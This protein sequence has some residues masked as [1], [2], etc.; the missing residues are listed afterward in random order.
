M[1]EMLLN[2]LYGSEEARQD[3]E[4]KLAQA[5]LVE[6]VA[7]EAGVDL[8]ELDD[9]ELEKFA[10]YVLSD[11]D[12]VIEVSS[13][14]DVE[15]VVGEDNEK[16]AEAELMGRTMAR[17]YAD[18]LSQI[19]SEGG[20]MD[21]VASA[22]ED[23]A[24]AWEMQKIAESDNSGRNAAIGGAAGAA[25]LG[26][27]A[28][29][30]RALS[31]KMLSNR[32]GDLGA[33]KKAKGTALKS[34]MAPFERALSEQERLF[35]EL[36][37]A[38]QQMGSRGG[39]TLGGAIGKRMKQRKEKMTKI[40]GMMDR[41]RA[42]F[43]DSDAAKSLN[44]NIS[45]AKDAL[46]AERGSF[47]RHLR[48]LSGGQLAALGAGGAA[49]G[50]GGAYLASRRKKNQEKKASLLLDH[51]YEALAI[52]ELYEPEEFAKEAELRAA[53]VLAANGIHPE[54]FEEIEP[55]AIKLASFP[56]VEDAVDH[57]EAVELAEYN[58]M[59]DAAAEHIL[60]NLLED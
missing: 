4:V 48:G 41:S 39:P 30:A 38:R 44:K 49:L 43:E 28:L 59:L 45:S 54:T 42:A 56:G 31:R 23:I 35:G 12:E 8:N 55:E 3:E 60:E 20:N 16:I 27:G 14:T 58:E 40:R 53:E 46:S 36:S 11:E 5:E 51:G 7:A 32:R 47:R 50:A 37:G 2:E 24:E 34:R 22:M 21:K 17:A 6:A 1:D 10:H 19:E 15:D 57:D 18:E 33:A 13:D 26:G 9:E 29:G 52:A 25:A